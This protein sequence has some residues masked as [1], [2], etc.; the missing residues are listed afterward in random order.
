MHGFCRSG[1][2]LAAE[3]VNGQ[4]VDKPVAER[5]SFGKK[6]VSSKHCGRKGPELAHSPIQLPTETPLDKGICECG[7]WGASWPA[8]LPKTRTLTKQLRSPN[9]FSTSGPL[10]NS[11]VGSGRKRQKQGIYPGVQDFRVRGGLAAEFVNSRPVD[12]PGGQPSLSTDR[13]LT[14]RWPSV[15]SFEISKLL[16]SFSAC[17]RR[18]KQARQFICPRGSPWPSEMVSLHAGGRSRHQSL[19]KACPFHKTTNVG[20]PACQQAVR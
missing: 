1:H 2:G 6:R 20:P 8:C 5:R 13:L 9:G 17:M 19:V 18:S 4:P 11:A 12:K 10:S 7:C 15:V 14:N 3:F 16:G